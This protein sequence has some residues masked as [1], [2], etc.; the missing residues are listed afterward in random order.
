M[1]KFVLAATMVL[2]TA[3]PAAAQ[4][5]QLM[6]DITADI[7]AGNEAI[8]TVTTAMEL[9]DTSTPDGNDALLLV[10]D[11]TLTSLALDPPHEC[12]AEHRSMVVRG[13]EAVEGIFTVGPDAGEAAIQPYVDE[14]IAVLVW[15]EDV[16]DVH[17]PAVTACA[18]IAAF[19]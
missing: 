2:M 15:M 11:N 10:I 7:T 19:E 1:K 3:A 17:V 4:D 13:L 5:L 9:F 12:V 6:E 14:F 18:T 8:S 16:E